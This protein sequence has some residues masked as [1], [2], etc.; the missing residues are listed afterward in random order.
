MNLGRKHRLALGS[1][2]AAIIRLPNGAYADSAETS[3]SLDTSAAGDSLGEVVVTAQRRSENIEKVPVAITA[4]S[5]KELEQRGVNGL[6]DLEQY[7]PSLKIEPNV[8]APMGLY[9]SLRG[10]AQT[11]TAA[12]D[13]GSVG[14]YQDDVYIGG[15]ALAGGVLTLGD[16]SQVEVLKGPQG[17]LYGRNVTAGLIKFDTNKPTNDWEGSVTA[18]VGNYSRHYGQIVINAPLISD[19]LAFRLVASGE[20]HSGF[21]YDTTAHRELE[22]LHHEGYRASLKFDPTENLDILVQSWGGY[23][24]DNGIDARTSYLEPGINSGSLDIMAAQHINGLSPG[25]LAPL[26]FGAAGGFTPAQIGAAYAEALAALPAV[27]ALVAQQLNASRGQAFGNAPQFPPHDH[28]QANGASAVVS[29]KFDEATLKSITAY[30]RD[31]RSN[32]FNVGGGPWEPIYTNQDGYNDQL[33]EELQ[34]TGDL[35]DSKLK[36]S[37]GLFLYRAYL[38]DNRIDS[39]IDG[40][41]PLF[42]G[43][44]GLGVLN[45]QIGTNNQTDKSAAAYTQATYSLTDSLHLTGGVRWTTETISARSFTEQLPDAATGGATICNG[46][47]PDVATTPLASCA[48]SSSIH[49]HNI[50][51]TGGLDDQLTDNLMLYVKTSRGF[52]SGGVNAYPPAYAPF[53][54]FQPEIAT[55]YEGGLKGV[56]L[57]RRLIVNA[58]YY[59]T[60]YSNIQLTISELIGAGD[61]VTETQNA[62]KATIQGVEFDAR[63]IPVTGVTLAA[64]GSYTYPKYGRY[65]QSNPAYPGGVEN[66][67]GEPFQDVSRWQGSLSIAYD[68]RLKSMSFRPEVDYTYRSAYSLF[69]DDTYPSTPGG[70]DFSP[71]S[72][73]TQGGY[74]LWNGSVSADL[75]NIHSTVTLWGKNLSNKRYTSSLI[76]L[77]NNGLGVDFSAYGPPTTVGLDYTYH[78]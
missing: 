28:A 16:V 68:Y 65:Q 14:T 59:H 44:D 73:T 51:Y 47:S 33:T 1:I 38:T 15:A 61:I 19:V 23:G 10:Q 53:A 78:F 72:A 40:A 31:T 4:F 49:N 48:Q 43:Q 66:L 37:G 36:Y 46:P 25:A 74:G 9:I 24:H 76:G 77:V 63:F 35:L 7:T 5:G 11:D 55:V 26:I 52:K 22:D 30:N 64:T 50:S 32:W 71:A 18:G 12:N 45:G 39:S 8:T 2:V 42:L 6:R 58:D 69:Q 20:E 21:S 54:T 27:N 70:L 13:P 75:P 62:A 3:A 60:S 41:F 56:W 29:Y 67:T 34:L 57:D 17:T